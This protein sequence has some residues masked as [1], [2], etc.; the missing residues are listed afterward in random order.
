MNGVGSFFLFKFFLSFEKWK[1]RGGYLRCH[2]GKPRKVWNKTL[3]VWIWGT[4]KGKEKYREEKFQKNFE[5]EIIIGDV[6]SKF[7]EDFISLWVGLHM[8]LQESKKTPSLLAFYV[9]LPIFQNT[10]CIDPIHVFIWPHPVYSTLPTTTIPN[11]Y[12]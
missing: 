6:R 7:F 3:H 4:S 5:A 9:P 1:T 12:I 10:A 2:V 8:S 11:I